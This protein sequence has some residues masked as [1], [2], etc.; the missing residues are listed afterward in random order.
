M[1]TAIERHFEFIDTKEGARSSICQEFEGRIP[2]CSN[3]WSYG[4]EWYGLQPDMFIFCCCKY[5]LQANL[6]Q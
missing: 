6:L 3:C 5:L 4:I 1:T 2:P